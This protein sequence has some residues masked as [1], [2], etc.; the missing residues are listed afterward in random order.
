MG[1][2]EPEGAGMRTFFCKL[3]P[4]RPTFMQDM[5]EAEAALMREHVAYWRGLLDSG[6]AVAYGPVDDPQGGYGIGIVAVE[7]EADIDALGA[8]DPTVKADRGFRFEALPMP[9]LITRA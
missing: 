9:R 4:P 8:N 1:R 7:D 2:R 5:T 3:I 6:Q